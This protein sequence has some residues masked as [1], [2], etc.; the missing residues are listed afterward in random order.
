MILYCRLSHKQYYMST[1][2]ADS[3]KIMYTR[4]QDI[5]VSDVDVGYPALYECEG[6]LIVI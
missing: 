6:F 5:N 3:S 1:P 2:P 4:V